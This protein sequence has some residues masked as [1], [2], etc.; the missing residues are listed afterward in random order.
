MFALTYFCCL[1]LLGSTLSNYAACLQLQEYLCNK[2]TKN[3][4]N[5]KYKCLVI[6]KHVARTGR[7]DF[8]KD[9]AKNVEVIKDCLRKG[10]FVDCRLS[11]HISSS[12]LP[13][14]LILSCFSFLLV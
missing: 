8:K 5:V 12:K 9:M 14:I 11:A 4:H 6:I 1:C 7:P 10:G 2:L 3:N 13:G